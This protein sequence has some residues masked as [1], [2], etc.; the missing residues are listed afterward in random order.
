MG[1]SIS[2]LLELMTSCAR[3]FS[4][5]KIAGRNLPETSSATNMSL[6]TP[7]A[8]HNSTKMMLYK[9]AVCYMPKMPVSALKQTFHLSTHVWIRVHV[10]AFKYLTYSKT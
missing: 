3:G 1:I 5:G 2:S 9:D 6:P 4:W 10:T 7:I 8:I